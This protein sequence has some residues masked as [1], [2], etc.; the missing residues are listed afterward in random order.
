MVPIVLADSVEER[1]PYVPDR[2]MLRRVAG[3]ERTEAM[4]HYATVE[5]TE[6]STAPRAYVVPAVPAPASSGADAGRAPAPGGPPGP[7][8]SGGAGPQP[9]SP[10]RDNQQMLSRIADR[11]AAHGIRFHRMKGERTV[12]A[13][14]FRIESSAV[15]EQGW[16]GMK[17]REVTGKWEA[18]QAALPAGSLVV[19]MDQPLARLAF[20]LLDARSDDGLMAWGL[21]DDVLAKTPAPAVYP[22]L[23]TMADVP[24]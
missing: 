17:I 6:T 16:Q 21:L 23:R 13:E 14:Q 7:G 18:T 9:A 24:E 10:Y 2:P 20:V 19:P 3:T 5:A 4:P 1:N 15:Q 11:L 22:V 8:G 12:A